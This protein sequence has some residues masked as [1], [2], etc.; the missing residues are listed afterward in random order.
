MKVLRRL[1]VT[2]RKPFYIVYYRFLFG[3]RYPGSAAANRFVRRFE[4]DTR[5]GDIPVSQREWEG[6]YRDGRWSYLRGDEETPRY[7]RLVE[8]LGRRAP[9]GAVLDVGCG[10]GLLRDRLGAEGYRRFV[11]VDLSE[12]AV[13]IARSRPDARAEF[14]VAAA[15]TYAPTECFD[16]V[17]FNEC[18]Y[19]FDDPLAVVERYAEAVAGGGV[20][21]VSMFRARRAKAIQR[22]LRASLPLVEESEVRTARG[23]WM[24][25]AFK[26]PAP[27]T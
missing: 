20:I 3:R 12:E 13:R 26:A 9:A 16:A 4:E 21:V 10:E 6:E 18:L 1:S 19:Y 14:A 27:G 7:T 2:A 22:L 5:R 17:V 11:G 25:S 15:E 24:V 8:L 23:T